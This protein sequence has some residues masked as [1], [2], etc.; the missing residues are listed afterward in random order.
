MSLVLRFAGGRRQLGGH[1][2]VE[3]VPVQLENLVFELSPQPNVIFH[4]LLDCGLRSFH[5]VHNLKQ[6][7]V[8]IVCGGGGG[9]RSNWVSDEGCV[10]ESGGCVEKERWWVGR[11]EGS[12]VRGCTGR[13]AGG[14]GVFW[15]FGFGVGDASGVGWGVIISRFSGKKMKMTDMG[16]GVAR[17]REDF[18]S[19]RMVGG[20]RRD[21]GFGIF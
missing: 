18:G 3:L 10:D 15:V 13:V 6:A 17:R 12:W 1:G 20:E 7:D 2:F 8:L 11:V 16:F 21:L 19:C 9:R 4:L 5:G 14:E